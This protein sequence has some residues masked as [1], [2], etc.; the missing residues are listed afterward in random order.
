MDEGSKFVVFVVVSTEIVDG[1]S[2]ELGRDDF[3]LDFSSSETFHF[4]KVFRKLSPFGII[5]TVRSY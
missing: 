4:L 2:E 3:R 5:F 1:I